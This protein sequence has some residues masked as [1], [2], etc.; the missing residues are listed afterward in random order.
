LD[1]KKKDVKKKDGKKARGQ[2][3]RG[4]AVVCDAGQADGAGTD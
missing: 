1:V 2:E 3:A 4:F